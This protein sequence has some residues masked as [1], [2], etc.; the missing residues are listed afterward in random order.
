MAASGSP[1]A[2][3]A[4]RFDSPVDS[5][6][7]PKLESLL[8]GADTALLR[9]QTAAG[10][11]PERDAI[12]DM[13]LRREVVSTRRLDGA[14]SSLRD[15]LALEAAL[16]G[17]EHAEGAQMWGRILR[18]LKAVVQN[19]HGGGLSDRVLADL[20]RM[21]GP[22]TGISGDDS[23]IR[24]LLEGSL[25]E[26]ANDGNQPAMVRVA[27][28]L[29][30]LER[31]GSLG[32]SSGWAGRFLA[33]V[34]LYRLCGIA[35]P[36][37]GA[38]LRLSDEYAD[39]RDALLRN[40]DWGRW[41][42]FFLRAVASGAEERVTEIGRA[43]AVRDRHR[44]MVSAHL[45]YAVGTALLV[46]DRMVEVPL[47]S[48]AD[49]RAI[50]GTSYVATNTLVSRLAALGILEEI[51]GYRRNRVFEYGAWVRVFAGG[52]DARG[53]V[54]APDRAAGPS[55]A[56]PPVRRGR[57]RTRPEVAVGT[58]RKAKAVASKRGGE[59]SDHLL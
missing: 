6:S 2:K 57:R 13:Q 11:A 24:E 41:T 34:L 27:L 49:V 28:T 17:A 21:L 5:Q 37:S 36:F 43:A 35:L 53:P 56:A 45:G 51:T 47:A 32:A 39:R 20:T 59:I 15:L 30:R 9:L 18:A 29:G 8:H 55:E 44:R 25:G 54:A 10:V 46:L 7:D 48:V 23:R 14:S 12:L 16:P 4:V 3:A 42:R 22:D 38:L 31:T 40:A 58:A 50:T 26:K 52:E 33:F 19:P 1:G